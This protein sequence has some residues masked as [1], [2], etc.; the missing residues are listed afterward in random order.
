MN[1]P[2]SNMLRYLLVI[3]FL[4]A[5]L[6][7]SG[8]VSKRKAITPASGEEQLEGEPETSDAQIP[9]GDE[10]LNKTFAGH[11]LTPGDEIEIQVF[12][13]PE[14][15]GKFLLDEDGRFRHPLMGMT[16]VAGLS[17]ADAEK[18]ITGLLEADFLVNP[19]VIVTLTRTLKSQ[20]V[21]LGEVKNPGVYPV[22]V[23]EKTTLLQVIALSGGFTGMASP[24]RVKI[25]RRKEDG[26]ITIPARVSDMLSGRGRQRD[27]ELEPDDVIMVPKIIF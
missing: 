4:A 6:G 25:V 13:E 8:C 14:F 7:V 5:S 16:A 27:I 2:F 10:A 19:R 9:T 20:I 18:M 22:P 11:V 17:V 26:T 12:R 15:S 1:S 23:N 24:D 3:T 21:I